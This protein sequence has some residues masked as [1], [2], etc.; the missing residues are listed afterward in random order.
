MK[1]VFAIASLLIISGFALAQ[2]VQKEKPSLSSSIHLRLSGYAQVLYSRWEDGVDSFQMRRARLS[3]AGEITRKI[4]FRLQADAVK[5]PTLVDAQVDFE[6]SPSAGLRIGQ[7]YV[8]FSRENRTSSSE[9]ETIFRSQVVEQLAPSRD[10][11]SRGRDIGAMLYGRYSFVEYMAGIFN[12]SGMNKTDTNDKKDFGA[13]VVFEP[14][15]FLSIG[16]SLYYGRHSETVGSSAVRRNRAGIE[17]SLSWGDLSFKGEYISGQ[18]DLTSKSGWYLQ[19]AYFLSPKTVQVV[20][21][22]DSYDPDRDV[23]SDRLDLLTL[24]L[25][26][27]FTDKTKLQVNYQYYWTEGQGKTNSA[28]LAQFQAGF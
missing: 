15:R 5:S 7:F 1:P 8:P 9:L 3:L 27:Y 14:V 4:R 18:D 11:G 20:L 16:G 2:E 25:N 12:G 10:I 26:W 17:S 23:A 6:F 13:R 24:G 28:L 19:G 22:F 21:R